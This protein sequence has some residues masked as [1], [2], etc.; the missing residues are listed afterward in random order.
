M[1]SRRNALWDQGH[2][3]AVQVNQRALIDKVLARYS[4][5]F[6]VFRE[7]LQNSD[8]A[9]SKA[10]EIHFETQEYLSARSGEGS[11]AASTSNLDSG[12]LPDLKK[13]QVH[14]WTFKNNGILFRNED[15]D[16]LKKIAEGNPDEDKIGAFGVG[17]YS[18]FSVTEEPFVTSGNKWMGFHWNK[19]QLL[20][21]RGETESTDAEAEKWTSFEM[22]LREAGPIPVAFDFTRFLASSI[23][24]M[25]TL[26]EISVYLD[27]K[28]LVRLTKGNSLPKPSTF[29]RY[30]TTRGP[31][32]IMSAKQ[33]RSTSVSIKAEVMRWV[34]TSGTEKPPLRPPVVKK[35]EKP[36]GFFKSLFS[37]AAATASTPQITPQQPPPPPPIRK[38]PRKVEETSVNLSIFTMDMDVT[39]D[40]K[41]TAELY[42]SMQK[43]PPKA[44]KYSLIYTAKDEYDASKK[45]DEQ[46]A[47]ELGSIFQ[48]LRADLDG[49]GT[50]KLF[51]GHATAQTT[52]L[53]GH[54]A[55][56][57]IPTV[58]RET[59]DLA[60]RNVAVW[61]R[62]LL[63]MG[64]ILARAAYEVELGG[65]RELWQGAGPS[66][67]DDLKTWLT[68][69]ALHAL[70]FFTFHQSTPSHAVSSL[71]EA[72]FFGCS[73]AKNFPLLSTSGVRADCSV[74]MPHA[75]YAAFLKQLPTVP[76]AIVDGAPAMVGALAARG[77]IRD[78]TF[79]DVLAELAARPLPEAEMVACMR[80]WADASKQLDR[81]RFESVRGQLL[82]AAVL[83][84]GSGTEGER[85]LPLSTIETYATPRTVILPEGPLPP[86]LLPAEVSKQFEPLVLASAF[87]WTELS[88]VEWLEHLC[89]NAVVGKDAAY[90][91]TANPEWAE[92]VLTT[93]AR[94]WPALSTALKG[95][96]LALLRDRTCVPTSAGLQKPQQAYFASADIFHDLPVVSLPSGTAVRGN[97]AKLL[98]DV[99]VRKHV[100]LQL[101][102][103]RMVKTN[104][105][106][107]PELVKYF[108]SVQSTLSPEE[109]RKLVSTK[110]FFAEGQVEKEDGKPTRY[111]AKDLYEPLDT[112]RQLGLPVIDWGT[113]VKWRSNSEEAQFL[114]K[115][116]LRRFPPLATLVGL[117]ASPDEKIRENA[118]KYL[119]AQFDQ[120]Y[121]KEY[122]PFD[123]R[124]IAFIPAMKGTMEKPIYCLVTP[125][126][127]HANVEWIVFGYTVVDPRAP[128]DIVTK[129]KIQKQPPTG[130]LVDQL[131]RNPP[132]D[133][134]QAKVWFSLLATRIAD[135]TNAELVALSALNMVPVRD[136]ETSVLRHLPPTHCFFGGQSKGQLHSKLFVFV[137]F[138]SAA[139]G[140]LSAVGT[141]QE[142][143]VEQIAQILL[144]DPYKFY[145]LSEGPQN[146]LNELRNIAVNSALVSSTTMARLK[147]GN[148]LLGIQRKPKQ[149]T[150]EEAEL[151]DED[152]WELQYDLK[153]PEEIVVADDSIAL[154][155]FG[156]KLFTAPQED[157]L[158]KFYANLGSRRLSSIVKEDFNFGGEVANHKPAQAIKALVLERLP[159]F[160][161]DHSHARTMRVQL[162]ADN[163]IVRS[164]G[165]LAVTKTLNFGRLRLSNRQDAS[166]VARR[167]GS[168]VELWVATNAQIDMYE[169]ATS[170]NRILF[171]SPRAHDA[172]LFMT[173]LST[174]LKSLKRRGYNVDRILRQKKA[175]HEAR[176][177]QQKAAT[178]LSARQRQEEE[179][180]PSVPGG[181]APPAPPKDAKPPISQ[182]PLPIA[183]RDSTDSSATAVEKAP[184]IMDSVTESLSRPQSTLQKW[185]N[186][187]GALPTPTPGPSMGGTMTPQPQPQG[188]AVT[189]WSN[190]DRNVDIAMQ[191]CRAESANVIKNGQEHMERVREALNEGYCDISNQVGD[192]TQLGTISSFRVYATPD[193][194]DKPTFLE[195]K[196]DALNRFI[197]VI[198]PLAHVYQL[199]LSSLHLFMDMSGGVIAFNRNGSIFLNLRYYEAWHDQEVRQGKL[200]QA[201][202]SNY[203]TLAHEIAHNLV[204]PHNAEHEFYFSA[205]CEKYMVS[206]SQLL[207]RSGA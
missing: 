180:T 131:R 190:I 48:G 46:V 129:L 104:Q 74:R 146:F 68:A 33:L 138:G 38:D 181:F 59:I 6:T 15:W 114:F 161:H 169:V 107:I 75:S 204:H 90:D 175:D 125:K 179:N 27:G 168:Q 149:A 185:K 115:L 11:K 42:R 117:C 81:G 197:G 73:P 140:F 18:L 164:F 124:D 133:E 143:T 199:P 98:Q 4:G 57:F 41:M 95:E 105:W 103:D 83:I 200:A 22:P 63:H 137:D 64:G 44:V 23:T 17:F 43:N 144:A 142:P 56:R 32:K 40:R 176:E 54:M 29:P 150:R 14:Q 120:R 51:I 170:L 174:D 165:T 45:E 157:I 88:T 3:E 191:G 189:P 126:E 166:A 118:M 162:T 192:L 182:P 153:R 121:S 60:D 148:V 66:P 20:A 79:D 160:L 67:S 196:R 39:L 116:G 172:L 82:G 91:L 100:E 47:S 113:Q 128:K 193:V 1:A 158:E 30:M 136:K 52:G 21:R 31:A 26:A 61:N 152:D 205:I 2:D 70:K 71:I 5:E 159:L 37:F 201:F 87:G 202:V 99:G 173:I 122:Q 28:R 86:H 134:E 80:W 110:A 62:E 156:D 151:D 119:L 101:I 50:T 53:G 135:F 108:A 195:R 12:D 109:M 77:I 84:L 96:A 78:V 167:N 9:Q 127:V 7:L 163:F 24:F 93:L 36:Q 49:Q 206:F 69:R 178:L 186:K 132:K 89:S 177:A 34:Y 187:F 65:I 188:P 194:P 198:M 85:I 58:E 55:S 76:D 183:A 102:F 13:I 141:K 111:L 155:I 184:S 154:Q 147:R 92:R 94:A 35:E 97:L 171:E 203:F 123:F 112:F 25:T 207:A 145:Q 10:V 106:T 19:D 8:D 130:L 139:N 72:G 16:R